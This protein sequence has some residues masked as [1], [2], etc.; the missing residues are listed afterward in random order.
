MPRNT[1]ALRVLF[2]TIACFTLLACNGKD[3]EPKTTV[4]ADSTTASTI[5]PAQPA[6]PYV[7]IDDGGK[8]GIPVL[9]VH[10]FG[11]STRHWAP[12]LAHLRKTRRAIAM[13]LRG[14]G[15]TPA[16]LD[17][18][19]SVEALATDIEKVVDSLDLER[20]VLVG[21]SMGGSAAIAYAGK[22]PNRVAALV[23]EGTPGKSTPE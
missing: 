2:S 14:H 20:V 13:D 9:F 8:G 23:L 10:S 18:N 19:Y 4:K 6:V 17:S 5:S 3:T 12:Q 11:G 1:Y 22:Y 15:K 21:H 16:P 7:F